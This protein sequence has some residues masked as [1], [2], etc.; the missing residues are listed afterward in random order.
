MNDE[1]LDHV[2]DRNVWMRV[3]FMLLYAAVYYVA[4]IV[5]SAVIIAQFLFVVVTGRKNGRL[6]GLGAQ[7]SA[8]IYQ[9]ITYL[10]YNTD[11]R[12]YPFRDWPEAQMLRAAAAK[13]AASASQAAAQ[14]EQTAKPEPAAKPAPT[15]KPKRAPAR[16]KPAAKKAE[17]EQSG[18]ETEKS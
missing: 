3:L 5:L 13:A 9:I 7:L 15:A 17:P 10:T 4:V 18:T 6:L 8:F 11:E 2:K 1:V 14:P 12:P 16:K